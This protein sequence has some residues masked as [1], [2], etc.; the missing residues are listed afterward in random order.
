MNAS[1][2]VDDSCAKK[3][4]KR[5][6]NVQRVKILVTLVL[7]H[8]LTYAVTHWGR[9]SCTAGQSPLVHEEQRG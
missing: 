8:C 6:V 9:H 1:E 2:Y 5:H 4:K 3:K 7:T